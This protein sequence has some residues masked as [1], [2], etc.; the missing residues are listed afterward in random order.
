M[1]FRFLIPLCVLGGVSISSANIVTNGGFEQPQIATSFI[2]L[3]NGS[4]AMNG[5]T[6]QANSGQGVDHINAT[7]LGN[8]NWAHSG[9]QA[10][11]MAG[12]PG[13]GSIYQDLTTVNGQSYNVSFWLSSNGGPFTNSLSV[14]WGGANVGTF[15]SPGFGSWTQFTI[16]GLVATSSTT[17][18]QFNG[19]FQ[20]NQGALLDDVSVVPEPM[21]LLALAPLAALARR[22]RRA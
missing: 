16:G 3:T 7:N 10:V 20:G 11:D 4:T 5:W 22:R 6:V 1:K 21:T 9:T 18:L 12:S 13:P 8:A 19:L 2:F 15:S 17:R 14:E